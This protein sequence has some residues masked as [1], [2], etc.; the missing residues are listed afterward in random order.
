MSINKSSYESKSQL[1]T[2]LGELNARLSQVEKQIELIGRRLGPE[3]KDILSQF[4]EI[5]ALM[6]RLRSDGNP[7]LAE[8]ARLQAVLDRFDRHAATFLREVGGKGVLQ[9]ARA[10]RQP[11]PEQWWWFTDER[12]AARQKALARRLLVWG[13]VIAV[14]LAG[15]GLIYN[16]F[17]APSPADRARSRHEFA[18]NEAAINEDWAGAL[19]EVDQAL[20]VDPDAPDLLVFK[21]ILQTQLGQAKEADESFAAAEKGLGERAAFLN[22]RGERYLALGFPDL[23]YADGLEQ[24]KLKPDSAAAYLLLGKADE[25]LGRYPEAIAEYQK[26]GDLADAQGNTVL[27]AM[28]RVLAATLSQRA[29]ILPDATPSPPSP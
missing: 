23:A 26:A 28:A 15:L 18:A 22:L 6:S 14:I 27:V 25:T 2:P 21:G 12:L 1:H 19:Q 11:A 3:A 5:Q 24:L 20:A 29:G 10:G 16:R 9:K 7:A 4:D 13:V 17:L 8:T